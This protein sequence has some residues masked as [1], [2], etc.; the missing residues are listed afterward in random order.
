[1]RLSPKEIKIM[2]D[3][4]EKS[5]R[6]FVFGESE[7]E[8]IK[9]VNIP[10]ILGNQKVKLRTE[11]IK[12]D[13]PWLIGRETMEKMGLIID[14]T[15]REICLRNVNNIRIKC[16]L[17]SKNHIRI[18]LIKEKG[19]EDI[20]L[21]NSWMENLNLCK[22]KLFKIHLQFGHASFGKIWNLI[23]NSCRNEEIFEKNKNK[24]REELKRICDE[25]LVCKRY[26]KNPNKPVVGLP[27]ASK[28][29]EMIA[30]DLGEIE[31]RRFIA[32][33]DMATNY[34]QAAW[35]KSKKPEEI[36]SKLMEKWI[37][38]FGASKFFF[39]DNGL[40]FQN[41]EVKLLTENFGIE[42]K[43]TPAESPW[44]NGKC[45]KMI[46][47]IKNSVRKLREDGTKDWDIALYWTVAAKN[48]LMM[49]SGLSPNQLVF[50]RNPY[51]PNLTGEVSITEMELETD[52]QKLEE[53]LRAMRK[54]REIHIKQES[55][56]RLKK[57][58]MKRVTEHKFEEAEIGDKV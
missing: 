12:G 9:V 26:K 8:S 28:F 15:K 45:E 16:Q 33:V 18:P 35:L 11:I 21:E 7:Y 57:A 51:F 58:L 42:V 25:C 27:M 43:C 47:L 41:E 19:M 31:G 52:D 17:D 23:E 37:S 29:N 48:N 56:E 34:V 54:A 39:S 53:N 46:G 4:Q 36:V 1:M 5:D 2:N 3:T 20:W 50:G 6:I 14:I 10:C 44:S 13:I 49:K 40:E 38:I 30:M 22:K 32:M 55:E 24:I